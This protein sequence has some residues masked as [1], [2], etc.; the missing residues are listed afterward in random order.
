MTFD[1]DFLQLS[2]LVRTF[3]VTLVKVGLNWPPPERILLNDYGIQAAT[4]TDPPE[5][6]LRRVSMSQITDEQR[7]DMTHVARGALYEY[8]GGG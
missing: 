2:L 6:V 5:L 8:E 4:E 3:R 7:Q 1:D